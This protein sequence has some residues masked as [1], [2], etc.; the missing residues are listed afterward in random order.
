M[1]EVY[2]QCVRCGGRISEKAEG[3][4]MY[5][6]YSHEGMR[7][8]WERGEL[9]LTLDKKVV[10]EVKDANEMDG[11]ELVERHGLQ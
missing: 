10:E 9:R 8:M 3:C 2:D 5:M 1:R 4:G 11:R 6:G 7:R